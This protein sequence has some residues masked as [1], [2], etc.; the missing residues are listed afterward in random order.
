MGIDIGKH[1]ATDILG[2]A[3]AAGAEVHDDDAFVGDVPNCMIETRPPF[4]L[5]LGK[6]CRPEAPSMM[7]DDP[8]HH[9]DAPARRS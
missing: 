9:D 1:E 6:R 7:A 4:S 2:R 3:A 5:D 8:S